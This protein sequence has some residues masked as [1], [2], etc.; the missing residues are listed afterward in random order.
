[1]VSIDRV[2]KVKETTEKLCYR[3]LIGHSHRHG[4]RGL[5][6]LRQR[7]WFLDS[8]NWPG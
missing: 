1:M 4:T 7:G 2:G 8:V 5:E 6:Q 3:D